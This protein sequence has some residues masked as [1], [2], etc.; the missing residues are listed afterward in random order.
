M[1]HNRKERRKGPDGLQRLFF[2]FSL[3]GWSAFLASLIVYHYARPEIA[4]S[5]FQP[6]DGQGYRDHWQEDLRQLYVYLLWGCC[7]I[8]LTSIA[9][10][11]SRSRRQT[12]YSK[13]NT[14]LLALIVIAALLGYYLNLFD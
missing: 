9:L 10:N 11:W 6:S 4:Y 5:A 12:D 13:I 1:P 3:I 14:G 8:T 2:V 7:G